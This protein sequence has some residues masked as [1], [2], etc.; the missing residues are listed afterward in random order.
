[1]HLSLHQSAR[2]GGAANYCMITGK[3]FVA[4]AFVDATE[5]SFAAA[6]HVATFEEASA[7]HVESAVDSATHAFDSYRQLPADT[8]A[9]F[10]ER[11]ALEIESNDELIP[12]AHVETA[13]P[14][15]RLTGERA[16]TVNQ[17]RMFAAL[18]REGSWV[19]ARVDR[20]LPQRTPVPRPDIRRM[21]VPIG[22]V[23]VFGA[24]NFPL[25]FSVA[26]GD[27][28]SAFAAG[29][30]VIVKAHPAHPATSE[31]AARAIIAAARASGLA[32]GVFSLLQSTRNDIARALVQHPGVKA[33]GF[34]GSLRAGRTLFDVAASR[35]EPIPVYAEMGSV[36]PVFVLPGA[37]TERGA[38]IAEGLK[39]SVTLGVGQFCTNPGLTI[40]L[41]DARFDAFVRQFDDLIRTAAP[42]TMLTPALCRA[43]EAGVSRLGGIEGVSTTRSSGRVDESQ[44][45]PSLFVTEAGVFLGHREVG[46]ELFGPSTVV[47]RC[48]SRDELETVA[49]EL[50]GQLTATIHGTPADLEEYA[51]LVSILEKKAGRLIVNGFPT[52][53]EV[54][55]SMQHGGPYPATTD[56]RST[57]V[58][59]AA[60]NRFARPVAYQNFP[61]SLLPPEL[62]DANPR[63]I[64]R[65]VDGELT[66]NRW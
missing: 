40:G 19:D 30:P 34:T 9:A 22:P 27:T 36:N 44:A 35:P 37:L 52:G 21:L 57:S 23:A 31:V 14:T 10:L 53:V 59:T 12:T 2:N 4:G 54:C 16:R 51:S 66:K 63:G 15:Q 45:R 56:S 55:P 13:L 17:L 65:L 3:N 39:E 5:G 28:A 26:G 47:V 58:G 49:R 43:Y 11:V 64:W 46:E 1:M 7:A 42:G 18:V 24:S 29:C 50:D 61:Q 32:P 8:R 20:A 62:Q 33:V 38:A 25:A 6:G 48:G 41:G 60:V